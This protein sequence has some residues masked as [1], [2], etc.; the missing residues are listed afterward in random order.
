MSLLVQLQ[1]LQHRM[2][3]LLL[4]KLQ[5]QKRQQKVRL[6]NHQQ[7]KAQQS[8]LLKAQQSQQPYLQQQNL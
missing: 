3:G 7:M 5:L 1:L 2:V 4:T 6:K 8:Q